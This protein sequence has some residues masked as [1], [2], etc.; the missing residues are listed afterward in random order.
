[1][2][3]SGMD[4]II[5][6]DYGFFNPNVIYLPF[7]DNEK[8]Q[9]IIF[10]YLDKYHEDISFFVIEPV[11]SSGGLKVSSELFYNKLLFKLRK[12]DIIS[13]FDEVATGFYRT[14][15]RLFSTRLNE[16]PDIL[17]LSKSINNGITP[18]GAVVISKDIEKNMI[19][20]DIEHFST[21]NGNLLGM[22][23]TKNTINFMK[24]NEINII[25]NVNFI[26]NETKKILDNYNLRCIVYGA[27]IAIEINSD[28]ILELVNDLKKF[29]ILVY[30]YSNSYSNGVTLFPV[31]TM[32]VGEFKKCLNV[33]LKKGEY[34]AKS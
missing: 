30:I 6:M 20:K 32:D 24:D 25:K 17:C 29:G 28:Y 5:N 27:I 22:I 9:N 14:G 4:Q 33:I 13:I 18:F 10:D 2:S 19:G 1:M 11:I 16:K 8:N 7:P 31:L 34:Y 26:Q 23:S 3:V 15:T 21:Q 12:Y